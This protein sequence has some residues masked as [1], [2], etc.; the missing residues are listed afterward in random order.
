MI[1]C[2]PALGQIGH[3]VQTVL[4][5]A[6]SAASVAADRATLA[7]TGH[8]VSYGT[9]AE[10]TFQS[11]RDYRSLRLTLSIRMDSP[12]CAG[13]THAL[14]LK[15]NGKPIQGAIDRAHNRLLNKPLLARTVSGSELPWVRGADWRVVYAPDFEILESAKAGKNRLVGGSAYRLVLDVTDLAAPGAEN[16]VTLEH[17][18]E[19]MG[20]RRYF[21]QTNPSLDFVLD[22][23][24]VEF[25]RE[26]SIG[27]A[28]RPDEEFRAERFMVQPP[29]GAEVDKVVTVQ[30]GGGLKISLPG[31][32]LNVVS[33]FSYQRGDFNYLSADGNCKG[34]PAWKVVVS[35]TAGETRIT[36]SGKEY[37]LERTVHFAGDHLEVSDRL[38]NLTDEAI[39]LAFDNRLVSPANEIIDAWLGGNPDPAVVTMDRLENSSVFAAGRESGCGLI[40]IDDVY[41]IQSVLYFDQGTGA[42]SD[43]FALG[44]K[45]TY[46]LRWNL[47]PLLRS[48]YF[49]FI[50]LARRDLGVNFT[51][52]GGFQFGLG[53][54]SDEAY[55]QMATE[56][57]LQF[58]AS[59]VW[60]DRSGEMK[61]YHGEHMLQATQLQQ[62]LREHCANIRRGIP[63]VKSLVYIHSFI[64]TDPAGPKKH[65]D[66]RITDEGGSQ[67][68]NKRYTQD[69]GIPF[70]Y[71]YPAL[72][73]EN[74]YFEAIKR[75]IDMCLDKDKIGADGIYWDELDW[76][77]TKYTF[78]R[79]DGHSAQ[80][81]DQY[82]IHRKMAYI[83][84]ISLTA[85]VKLIE[86]IRN[87][88]GLLIGNSVA[89]T[90][91]LSRI[92][93]PRFVET[94]AGWYPARS[95]L[96]SPISLG[97]HKTVKDFPGL[98][99]DIRA[100]LMWG[101]V[102]YYYAAPKQPYPTITAKMF[103]FT[104]VELHR[105]WLL[106]KEKILT[107]V[108]G[109]FTLGD[110]D[111][112]TVYWYDSAGKLTEQ[113]GEER[114]QNGRRWIRLALGEKE[115]AVIE[116]Q[117]NVAPPGRPR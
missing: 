15:L 54:G 103:P 12:H 73:P 37:R 55:R 60:F 51:I 80:L 113:H 13:S 11:S 110:D 92:H 68:E 20:L 70:F 30:P 31:L 24:A 8:V 86:Y 75:I 114:L 79:W 99:E 83:H 48:D 101:T 2:F 1:K 66:A 45:D 47:Y 117:P 33:R 4:M 76:I 89:S 98:L 106:G 61:C 41:R 97:D 44:P 14:R 95:H 25:S 67:Y 109:T 9:T 49:D 17:L 64:N 29:A 108:P 53:A 23:L 5:I 32:S 71:N 63:H 6:L 72:D 59:G 7:P 56:R 78:D 96:Y 28:S 116:R 57:G 81:D 18:G 107:A 43:T 74:S 46:T 93:F 69:T 77:S 26:P 91:T 105:G 10:Y 35:Q 39:G 52:P 115:M 38:T 21:S 94:A 27:R 102:Y 65:A 22:E 82:R 112:V 36:G 34:E 85:K 19:T 40:A 50:N 58:M 84:L 104:P 88:G 42:R 16:K 87:K 3:V 111:P 100:K 62:R 90:D